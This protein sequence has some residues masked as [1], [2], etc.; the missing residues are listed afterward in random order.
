MGAV[1]RA[2]QSYYTENT[3]FA[4]TADDLEVPLPSKAA[5]TSKYYDFT[6]GS[7]GAVGSILALNANNDKDG[8]RDYIG[9]TSYNTTDRAFATVVCRVNKDVTG[10]FGTHLTNEG[11]ITSGSGTNVACAG[12]S[13]AVK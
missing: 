6:L 7:G 11:I 3:A 1:N 12:T 8:T 5:G 13:K 2:Q 9:G 10:A 4:E